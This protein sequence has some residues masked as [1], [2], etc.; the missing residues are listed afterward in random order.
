VST[1]EQLPGE[2]AGAA[3]GSDVARD[4]RTYVRAAAD[5][6]L[7]SF[8]RSTDGTWH[9]Y[10]LLGVIQRWSIGESD[11]SLNGSWQ[12]AWALLPLSEGRSLLRN[13]AV[14]GAER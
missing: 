2:R 3:R 5:A 12:G 14:C 10:H 11:P 13:D 7:R 6:V 4:S 8:F 9:I 1:A